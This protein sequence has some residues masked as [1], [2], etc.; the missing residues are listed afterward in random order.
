VLGGWGRH[1]RE[2]KSK[3]FKDEKCQIALGV[4]GHY[5]T[6]VKKATELHVSIYGLNLVF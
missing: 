3:E 2:I 6:R 4:E 5:A 1:S